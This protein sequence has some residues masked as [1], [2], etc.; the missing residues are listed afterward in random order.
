MSRRAAAHEHRTLGE[1][2]RRGEYSRGPPRNLQAHWQAELRLA[3]TRRERLRRARAENLD[4]RRD[5]QLDPDEVPVRI[6]YLPL[7]YDVPIPPTG[8][9]PSAPPTMRGILAPS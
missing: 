6:T 9:V 8:P 4:Q 1:E 2:S 3:L 7:K 5:R